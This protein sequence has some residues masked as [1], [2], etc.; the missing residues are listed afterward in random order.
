MFIVGSYSDRHV[1]VREYRQCAVRFRG[2]GCTLD[3]LICSKPNI[4]G[5]VACSPEQLCSRVFVEHPFAE[6]AE[7]LPLKAAVLMGE[8]DITA[9]LGLEEIS[10][11]TMNCLFRKATG[12]FP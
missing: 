1:Q 9:N 10:I 8:S 12:K 5:R 6:C 3:V 4:D 7:F 2:H 11:H